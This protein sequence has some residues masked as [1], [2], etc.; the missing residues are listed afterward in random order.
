MLVLMVKNPTPIF[1]VCDCDSLTANR[2]LIFFL[3]LGGNTWQTT[4]EKSVF[5][6]W[7][8]CKT[9]GLQG[10]RK[11][12]KNRISEN[13]KEQYPPWDKTSVFMCM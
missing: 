2:H 3:N 7:I 6:Q 9:Q 13:K 8:A 10:V 5:W 11:R 1:P 12:D 4:A